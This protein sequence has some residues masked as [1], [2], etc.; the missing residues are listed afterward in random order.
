MA[1]KRGPRTRRR[2]FRKKHQTRK[3]RRPQ[4]KSIHPRSVLNLSN[5]NTNGNVGALYSPVSTPGKNN[6]RTPNSP[7]TMKAKLLASMYPNRASMIQRSSSFNNGNIE[8]EETWWK[9]AEAELGT[10]NKPYYRN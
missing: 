8:T 9:R 6:T 10:E 5:S 7:I 3:H 1:T 2:Y 4:T